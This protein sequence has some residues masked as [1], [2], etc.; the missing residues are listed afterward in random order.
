MSP[1]FGLQFNNAHMHIAIV[2]NVLLLKV[3][4]PL[5]SVWYGEIDGKW[6]T[7]PDSKLNL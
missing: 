4:Q 2:H 1:V 5:E 3:G 7:G 6:T